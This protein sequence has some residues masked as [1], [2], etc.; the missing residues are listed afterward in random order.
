M[1]N[2]NKLRVKPNRLRRARRNWSLTYL[3]LENSLR[4]RNWYEFLSLVPIAP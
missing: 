3:T 4:L 1:K 2:L